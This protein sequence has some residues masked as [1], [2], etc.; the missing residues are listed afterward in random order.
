MSVSKTAAK[1][2]RV[3]AILFKTG[4]FL[5][6]N[7]SIASW[8]RCNLKTNGFDTELHPAELEGLLL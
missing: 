5:S 8:I 3:V 2:A 1:S 6:D 7:T 4:S